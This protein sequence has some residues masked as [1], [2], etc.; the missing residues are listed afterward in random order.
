MLEAW[1]R[2]VTGGVSSPRDGHYLDADQPHFFT[3]SSRDYTLDFDMHFDLLLIPL[4][5][6]KIQFRY[7]LRPLS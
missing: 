4:P 6:F 5:E 2:L 3:Q 1:I 7:R